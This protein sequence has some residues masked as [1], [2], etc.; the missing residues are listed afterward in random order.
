[1][2][3]HSPREVFELFYPETL[4][5]GMFAFY[6]TT[7]KKRNEHT[8]WCHQLPQADR[9]CRGFRNTRQVWFCPALHS[10]EK[11]LRIAQERRR[12]ARPNSIRGCAASVTALPA[13]W[14]VLPWGNE[15]APGARRPAPAG[16]GFDRTPLLPPGRR[17]ALGLLEAVRRQP[18]LIIAIH[19]GATRGGRRDL[20][21]AGVIY[22]FWLLRRPWLFDPEDPSDTE[23]TAATALQAR[24]QG[25]VAR[26]AA[27]RGWQL[28]ATGAA[29]DLAAA[30][31]LPGFPTGDRARGPRA[32]L[33][34]FPLLPGDAR[35]RRRDFA[36][37]PEP[38]APDPQPWRA[39]MAPPAGAARRRRTFA[40]PPIAEGCSWI[41][42]CRAERANLSQEQ[43]AN[44]VRLLIWCTAPGAD[45]GELVHELYRGHPGYHR[46]DVD[47]LLARE[48]RATVEPITCTRIGREP[49]VV[50]RHCS[51]C[52]HF[53][54]IEAPVE[55]ALAGGAD[56]DAVAEPVTPITAPA[57]AAAP[58]PA[59]PAAPAAGARTRIVITCRRHEI[60]DQALAILAAAV[61]LFELRGT[62]VELVRY[63]GAAPA[64][65]RVRGP[66]LEE[67]LSRHCEFVEVD[68]GGESR[69][70]PPPRW[71]TRGLLA[72]GRWP[73]LPQL[74]GGP[75]IRAAG[76]AFG[77]PAS[78][79]GLGQGVELQARVSGALE[80]GPEIRA[81]GFGPGSQNGLGQGVELRAPAARAVP[82]P[83]DQDLLAD[84]AP[85][86][87]ALGGAATARR[88]T[89]ALA[90]EPERF[91][92]LATA[93]ERLTPELAPGDPAA[94]VVLGYRLRSLK[95]RA[96]G[97]RVLVEKRRTHEGIAWA[98]ESAPL[99]TVL[100]STRPEPK[101]ENRMNI[102]DLWDSHGP[103]AADLNVLE[104]LGRHRHAFESVRP[105]GEHQTTVRNRLLSLLD[106]MEEIVCAEGGSAPALAEAWEQVDELEARYW[107]TGHPSS[108]SARPDSAAQGG[109]GR[110]SARPP[111]I[112]RQG[113]ARAAAGPH[114]DAAA[115]PSLA[116]NEPG[117][118]RQA[119]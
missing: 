86:I 96:L 59:E 20:G 44:A 42:A 72:R 24:V 99:E 116:A 117:P 34:S 47:R 2:P 111:K 62:L 77:P 108:P 64:L 61:E 29:V 105:A 5:T 30:F 119:A 82:A 33:E 92:A 32:V 98:L 1:M 115:E 90:A 54:R 41:R 74:V 57:P 93:F 106:E 55:L 36:S 75:E 39:V 68:P 3:N 17:E 21:S 27:E 8:H 76:A 84:L 114:P 23:R 28:G 22:A 85:V 71:T 11:A 35:Y 73:E 91:G 112:L 81:A 60:N 118:T 78:Q 66:R 7:L 87:D 103:S 38:P 58:D 79:D 13:L 94:S 100:P 49:G 46:L 110:S 40:F 109:P 31:P 65:R 104:R 14:A 37:L 48:L 50:E 52:P 63:P 53:G 6:S 12:Q 88:I 19:S 95:G 97:G 101:E 45:A 67:L 69:A 16:P 51:K 102:D 56:P 89:G 43:L 26:L 4:P 10:Q 80:G 9:L 107:E 18:S 113:P 83:T 70:V 25:A 15:L